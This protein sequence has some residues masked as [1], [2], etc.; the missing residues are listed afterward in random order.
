MNIKHIISAIRDHAI[1][2]L[3]FLII[4]FAYTYPSLEGKQLKQH[5]VVTFKGAAEE[6]RQFEE[7]TGET[8]LWTNSLFG[9]MPTYLINTPKSPNYIK[10]L[11]NLLNI[12]HIFRNTHHT[13]R[14]DHQTFL[15]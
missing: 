3:L 10:P 13:N 15:R 1:V 11:N 5:D 4:A 2:I 8:T 12:F 9:G 6:K 14:S 7:K